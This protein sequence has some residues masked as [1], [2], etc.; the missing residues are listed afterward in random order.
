[1][2]GMSGM[3]GMDMGMNMFQSDNMAL[4]RDYWY[5]VAGFLGAVL[6][7]RIINLAEARTR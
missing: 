7:V 6:V 3:G 5:I 2:D 4:A 1:M